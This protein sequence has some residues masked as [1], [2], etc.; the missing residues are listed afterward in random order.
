MPYDILTTVRRHGQYLPKRSTL[1]LD[2]AKG[3]TVTVDR[4]TLWVTLE[5]DPRDIILGRG[6]NFRIDR[7]GRTIVAAEEDSWV[8]LIRQRTL[9][10]RFR[11]LLGRA[12]SA[13]NRAWLRKA[14][15]PRPVPYY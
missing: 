4:G 1:V 12:K 15:H 3:T 11:A 7:S 8:R 9:P 2:G 14:Q 6:M 10:E 13:I 5:S